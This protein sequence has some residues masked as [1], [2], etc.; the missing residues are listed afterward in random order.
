MTLRRKGNVRPEGIGG[1]PAPARVVEKRSGECDAIGPPFGNDRL[2]LTRP[3]AMI[4]SEYSPRQ[5]G[6]IRPSGVT[7]STITIPAPDRDSE[8]RCCWCQSFADPSTAL[9]WH[10][11]DTAMRLASVRPPMVIG[12]NSFDVIG[13]PKAVYQRVAARRRPAVL[14]CGGVISKMIPPILHLAGSTWDI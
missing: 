7:V 6:V 5:T 9:Y 2:G 1:V 3:S 4:A 8:P 13:D 12:E 10:I 11:G 14:D